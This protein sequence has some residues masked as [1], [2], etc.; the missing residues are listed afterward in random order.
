MSPRFRH[1]TSGGSELERLYAGVMSA[2]PGSFQSVTSTVNRRTYRSG[3]DPP[4]TRPGSPGRQSFRLRGRR[5]GR[6]QLAIRA[7]ARRYPRRH[8]ISASEISGSHLPSLRRQ[9]QHR[10]DERLRQCQL[11]GVAPS[12]SRLGRWR[13]AILCHR[14]SGRDEIRRRLFGLGG[15]RVRRRPVLASGRV[16]RLAPRVARRRRQSSMRSATIGA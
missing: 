14:R 7:L 15:Q 16:G 4:S 6:P 11:A 3:H 12:A 5:A 9:S 8:R 2:E 1:P 13:L 10:G